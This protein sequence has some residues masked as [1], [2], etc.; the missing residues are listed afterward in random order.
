MQVPNPAQPVKRLQQ[1]FSQPQYQPQQQVWQAPPQ[2]QM[3]G[4]SPEAQ[5][6]SQMHELAMEI[7]ARLAVIHIG[8]GGLDADDLR[9]LATDAQAAAKA[10]YE[11]LG[12]Q[13]HNHQES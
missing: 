7:Y 11:S 12:V 8:T 5:I 10:Y 9:L 4:A 3:P 13:F 1:S 2:Q 6:Q